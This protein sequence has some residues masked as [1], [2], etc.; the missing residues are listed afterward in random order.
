M[1]NKS[2]PFFPSS[3]VLWVSAA[4]INIP[5]AKVS[6]KT[7]ERCKAGKPAKIKDMA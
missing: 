4:F 3:I 7:V 2:V 6:I 5:E 1:E